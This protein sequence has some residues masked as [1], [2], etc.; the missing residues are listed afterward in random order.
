VILLLLLL[1]GVVGVLLLVVTGRNGR[2]WAI[3]GRAG[4]V[5]IMSLVLLIRIM[6]LVLLI[7]MTLGLSVGFEIRSGEAIRGRPCGWPWGWGRHRRLVRPGEKS[8]VLSGS[9][10]NGI[11]PVV[12]L[13][14]GRK[15]AIDCSRSQYRV[16]QVVLLNRSICLD[17]VHIDVFLQF[18]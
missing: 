15:T 11:F 2:R 12:V 10:R 4:R 13:I 16:N 6:G 3:G 7:R 9:V 14:H 17:V 5:L 1:V 8:A 18:R